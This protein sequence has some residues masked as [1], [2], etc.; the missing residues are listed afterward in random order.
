MSCLG[1]TG[2]KEQLRILKIA[3][4]Q[5]LLELCQWIHEVRVGI[6]SCG[7]DW[8]AVCYSVNEPEA[9]LCSGLYQALTLIKIEW[10]VWSLE[11]YSLHLIKC[12]LLHRERILKCLKVVGC[13]SLHISNPFS[14]WKNNAC[15]YVFKEHFVPLIKC[16]TY[17]RVD[18]L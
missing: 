4:S 11:L 13:Y 10:I 1:E 18:K 16:N 12:I 5:E 2:R 14:R 7:T 6:S 8:G 3:H 15:T 17:F 9:L